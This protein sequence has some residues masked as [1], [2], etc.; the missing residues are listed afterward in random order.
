MPVLE[1][2][3]GAGCWAP[4]LV[5]VPVPVRAYSISTGDCLYTGQSPSAQTSEGRRS[6]AKTGGCMRHG[7]CY[8]GDW[9][10]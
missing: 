1:L 7:L 3:A 9:P 2:G 8:P 6:V 4:V 5:R 10:V